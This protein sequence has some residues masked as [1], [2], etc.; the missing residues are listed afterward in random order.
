MDR[1]GVSFQIHIDSLPDL[2][3]FTGPLKTPRKAVRAP[4]L[5]ADAV[6][7]GEQAARVMAALDAPG[8]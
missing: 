6:V 3:S 4:G 1:K 2:A 5:A 8:P 7:D